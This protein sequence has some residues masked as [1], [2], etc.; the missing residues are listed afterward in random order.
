MPY[1]V[2]PAQLIRM[3]KQ[4]QNPQ[5]LMMTVLQQS[6]AGNPLLENL[7]E[8][9]QQNQTKEIEQVNRTMFADNGLDF[10]SEFNR[11]KSN[12]GL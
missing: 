2:N 4:G 9:A 6:T 7:Y 1:N 5:Q 11:F 3:I 12:L 8:L 10:D